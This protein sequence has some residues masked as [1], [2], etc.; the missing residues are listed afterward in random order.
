VLVVVV[1]AAGVLHLAPVPP[2]SAGAVRDAKVAI[3]DGR[4]A[5]AARI[6]GRNGYDDRPRVLANIVYGAGVLAV[7]ADNGEAF[8]KAVA[9]AFVRGGVT[10][11]TAQRA[12]FH[13]VALVVSNAPHDEQLL[14][15]IGPGGMAILR[16]ELAYAR[17]AA[18]AETAAH[19]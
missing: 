4:C 10:F 11:A 5:A 1:L 17:Q 2:A 9:V 16:T 12:F 14:A 18:S 15:E 6:I 7:R 3:A 8:S 13:G 19:S